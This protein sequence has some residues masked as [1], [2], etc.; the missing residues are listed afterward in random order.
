MRREEVTKIFLAWVG[1]VGEEGG[2]DQIVSA[3][4]AGILFESLWECGGDYSGYV[5][6]VNDRI[7]C[8]IRMHDPL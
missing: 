4:R 6:L 3:A 2:R 5:G 7:K 1:S 8:E